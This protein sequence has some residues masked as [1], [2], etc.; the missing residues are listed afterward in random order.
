MQVQVRC[1]QKSAMAL[2][3]DIGGDDTAPAGKTYCNPSN[4]LKLTH[5]LIIH[6]LAEDATDDGRHDEYQERCKPPL[7]G[8]RSNMYTQPVLPRVS[9]CRI[10]QE[11]TRKMDLRWGAA[12]CLP[13]SR[14]SSG[15]AGTTR[16]QELMAAGSAQRSEVPLQPSRF[17]AFCSSVRTGKRL[18]EKTLP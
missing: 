2:V 6:D 13:A 11:S 3:T 5:L 7:G 9:F 10:T 1:V 18:A 14:C 12:G 16:G 8:L 4:Q 15:R 17:Q